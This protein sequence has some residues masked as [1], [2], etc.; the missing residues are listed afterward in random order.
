MSESQSGSEKQGK[1]TRRQ[2]LGTGAAVA[3]AVAV[4]GLARSG[5]AGAAA[6]GPSATTV[7][8]G[9]FKKALN[10]L[11]KDA[12]FRNQAMASP[13][14]ITSTF[15]LTVGELEM[16]RQVA[17]LSGTD[18]VQLNK[19][20]AAKLT[21]SSGVVLHNGG[22]GWSISCCSCCCCCSGATAVLSRS[23]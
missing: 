2:A 15:Q 10:R 8:A 14:M 23:A 3:G 13:G 9:E 12:T 7:V 16:L 5:D 19:A 11:A 1:M 17:I 20:R 18:T 22:G 4:G 21:N 6:F